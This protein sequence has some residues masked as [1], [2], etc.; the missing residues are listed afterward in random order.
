MNQRVKLDNW[1][2]QQPLVAVKSIHLDPR[3]WWVTNPEESEEQTYGPVQDRFD[4]IRSE[5][6]ADGEKGDDENG[7]Y[8][9]S[10]GRKFPKISHRA[11]VRVDAFFRGTG[12][13]L[14]GFG[15]VAIIRRTTASARRAA[16]S[17]L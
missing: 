1:R 12:L 9:L 3:L 10:K 15:G 17:S 8:R 4:S 11:L 16:S 2:L 13:G 5:K 14:C 7:G 6:H